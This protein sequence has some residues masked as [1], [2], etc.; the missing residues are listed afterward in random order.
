[1]LGS[2]FFSRKPRTMNPE[3]WVALIGG[4]A[5]AA[6][7]IVPVL[8]SNRKTR[9]AVQPMSDFAFDVKESL[10]RIHERI[11]DLSERVARMDERLDQHLSDHELHRVVPLRR[12]RKR[13]AM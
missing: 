9:R 7:A 5:A 8:I 4:V 10:L 2:L 6:S 13:R 1:M 3:I 11:G 12:D